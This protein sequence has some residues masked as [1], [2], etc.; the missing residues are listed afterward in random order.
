MLTDY[1]NNRDDRDIALLKEP[2]PPTEVDVR[3]REERLNLSARSKRLR[4]E[5]GAK[6]WGL[7]F[8]IWLVFICVGLV[9]IC[10]V[11]H[12]FLPVNYQWLD[13]I[14]L[15]KID[16]FLATGVLSGGVTMFFKARFA[17]NQ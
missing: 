12:L 3:A 2:V 15:R 16:E 11:C 10:K 4:R 6:H 9:F 13:D 7:V 14:H 8:L 17:H 5:E 1:P